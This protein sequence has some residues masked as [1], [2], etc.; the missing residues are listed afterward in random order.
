M[1]KNKKII[2]EFISEDSEAFS[3]EF[4]ILNHE[5]LQI[6]SMLKKYGLT[7]L[8]FVIACQNEK[9]GEKQ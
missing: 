7:K 6:D 2:K 4:N 5:K 8:L 9:M 3:I 1:V